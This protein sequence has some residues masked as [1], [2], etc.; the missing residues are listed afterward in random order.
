M[1][2]R[3]LMARAR[4]AAR[5]PLKGRTW[6]ALG[7]LT[8]LAVTSVVV[9]RRALGVATAR[10]ISKLETERRALESAR[11]KLAQDLGDAASRGQVVAQAQRRLGMHVAVESQVR[12]LADSS[13]R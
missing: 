13:P 8:F 2:T 4:K 6:V 9:W 5:A 7:L 10:Q 11:T 3:P 1:A 12:F